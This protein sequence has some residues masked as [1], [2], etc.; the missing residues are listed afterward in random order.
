MSLLTSDKTNLQHSRHLQRRSMF[1]R[2]SARASSN[3]N[4][5]AQPPALR[6]AP[7]F[8]S[9]TSETSPDPSSRPKSRVSKRSVFVAAWTALGVV[10]GWQIYNYNSKRDS[11]VAYTLVS[12]QPVSSTASI[13]H[14]EPKQPSSNFE[15]YKE[16][17]RKGIWNVDFKQPQLQIVRAYTPLPP[18]EEGTD[19]EKKNKEKH[20]ELRFLIRKDPHGEVSSY[21]HKLPIGAEIE[22]RG[23]NLEYELTPD[24]RQIVFFAGGTGIAP[25]L[26]IAHALFEGHNDD[27]GDDSG[28]Q[29]KGNSKTKNLHI[30]WASRMREDCAG[31]V[32]DAAPSETVPPKPTW[33]GLFSRPKAKKPN[34]PPPQSSEKGLIVKEL[35]A[36][37]EKY[38]GQVTVEYFVNAEDTWIDEDAVF[39]ALSR[40]DDKEFSAGTAAPGQRQILISGPPGFIS[41]LAGPKEWRGGREEQGPVSRIVAHAISKNPHDVTVWKI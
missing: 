33:S 1:A 4:H 14:L 37:K 30:L 2:C 13:F 40:F 34:T 26:Q 36:L 29:Q 20:D 21:L 22:M 24:V 32:S 28:R 10:A 6:I 27:H 38:P 7:R 18:V 19:A 8:K 5:A 11:F 16:A 25:A 23:P 12:K 9:T 15:K 39:R 41:Y 35:D 31:G 3:L 17:W